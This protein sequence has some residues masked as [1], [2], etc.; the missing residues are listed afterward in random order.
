MFES[1]D[2]ATETQQVIWIET[3]PLPQATASSFYRKLDETL[4]STG[5]TAG[6]REICRPAGHRSGGLFQDAHD[7]LLRKPA[8]RAGDRELLRG[9]ALA[10]GV[11]R[12]AEVEGSR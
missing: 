8:Q 12:L 7:R 1:R 4:E 11:P 6:V 2:A 3:R 10:A 9:L 5:F